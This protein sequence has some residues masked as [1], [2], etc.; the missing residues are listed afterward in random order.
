MSLIKPPRT[1]RTWLA[2][3][4]QGVNSAQ[5]TE[6]LP[7]LRCTALL[8]QRRPGLLANNLSESP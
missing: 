7:D 4:P 5:A 3:F 8:S 1:R 6:L 2:A